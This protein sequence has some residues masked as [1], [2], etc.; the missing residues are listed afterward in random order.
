MPG[1]RTYV[2]SRTLP[3]AS[4]KGVEV[5][6]DV[7]QLAELRNDA[8]KDIWLFGGGILFGSLLSAG[9]VDRIEV[10]IVPVLLG[11]GR[12]LLSGP[13]FRTPLQLISTAQ[14]PMGLVTL[15]YE[16]PGRS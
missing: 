7:S 11:A 16:L 14:T 8:G 12:A 5:L 3:S 2:F 15:I 9:L 4:Q 10:T 6:N 1:V 13:A